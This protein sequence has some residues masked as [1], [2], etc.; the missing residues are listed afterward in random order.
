M[1]NE[2][3]IVCDLLPTYIDQLCSKESE[4]F[5]EKHLAQCDSCAEMLFHMKRELHQ[6]E[7]AERI[8]RLEQK[9]PLEKIS[10]FMKAELGFS[11][12]LRVSFW[13]SLSLA[14][15]LF[16]FALINFNSWQEDQKEQQRVAQQQRAIMEE[17][18]TALS[19]QSRPNETALQAVFQRYEEQLQHIAV[20][21]SSNVKEASNWQQEPINIFPI[22]YE[23]A[24][25][26]IGQN[27]EIT[28]TIEPNDYDIG[29]MVMAND[30]WVIQFEYKKSY[31]ETVE[32]AF[33]I[34]HYAPNAFELFAVPFIIFVVTMILFIAWRYQKRIMKPVKTLIA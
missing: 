9:K 23:K 8:E 19:T 11:K 30:K 32:S 34:K 29:T 12:L 17:T 3:Y 16:A 10:R 27:G 20:F 18:F 22:E 33:Q 14:I 6:E 1:N 24:L 5:I 4:A 13:I 26:V 2:C 7:D 21:A 31:L 25:I 28:E 15:V